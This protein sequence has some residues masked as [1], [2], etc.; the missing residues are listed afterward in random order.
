MEAVLMT[1]TTPRQ[2]VALAVRSILLASAICSLTLGTALAAE[3]SSE[4]MD[5]LETVTVTGSRIASR[6]M[7]ST[8]PILTVTSEDI[9]TGGRLD[10]TDMLNQLPQINSNA[11]G[12]DLGNRTSGLTSAGGVSTVNLRG[13]GANRTLLLVDGRRLGQGSPQTSISA[14]APDVDQVPS[15]LIERV[16]V[17][18]GGASAVYGSDAIAGVVN[19]VMK[20]NFE[21]VQ[22]DGQFGGNWHNNNN[23][24]ARQRVTDAG[25]DV[26][27]GNKWDGN[28]SN[29][30]L[31]AGKNFFDGRG[32][33]TAY[34][35]HSSMAP[36]RSSD[37]DFGS[38]M[39]NYTSGLEN[40]RC[41][42]SSNANFFYPTNTAANVADG[43][44]SVSGSSF[45]DRGSVDT[46]P[47]AVFNGQPYIYMQRDDDRY[48]GGL[49][50]H[51]DVNDHFKPYAEFAYMK[52]K[53][54]QEVAPTALFRGSNPLSD[55]GNYL[56][57]CSNPLLSAQQAALMC[58]P[59][60]IAA[61]AL[62]PGSVNADVEIGRRNVEGGGRTYDY[63]HQNYR[64]VLGT[65]GDL[66]EGWTYD[67]YGQYYKV[68]FNYIN[69]KD[70]GFDK[71]ANALQVSNGGSG[72]AC[73]SGGDC[74]PYNIF[75]EGAVTQDMLD[76]LTTRGTSKGS[77]TLETFHA[78]T[79]GDLG[80]YGLQLPSANE[81]VAIN[82]GYEYRKEHVKFVPD[83]AIE[84]GLIVGAGGADP[85][86]SNSVSVNELSAELRVPIASGL[87]GVHD[88]VAGA[89]YRYSDYSTAGGVNTY[90]F[91][92]Q[93]APMPDLRFRASF[94]RAIRAP[95]IVELFVPQ[96]VGKISFG[97]DPCAPSED[98]GTLNA[99]FE[100]CARTGVTQAQYNNLSIPQGTAGQLTQLQGGNPNLKPESADTLTIGLTLRPE[101]APGFTGSIDYYHIKT[102][103][104]V[105]SLPANLILENCLNTGDPTFCSQLVRHPVT[106]TLNGAS[107]QSGGYIVKTNVNVGAGVLNGVDMQAGYRLPLGSAGNL[108][109]SLNSAYMLSNTSTPIP[110]GGSYDCAGLFG[111]T[112]QTV[113]PEWRHNASAAWEMANDVTI[114][115]IWRFSSGVKLDHN[116]SDP[117]LYLSISDFADELVYRAKMP[118][119]SYFDLSGKW[120]INENFTVRAGINNL[121]D[122]DP[123]IAP[124]EI[125]SGGAPN[126]YEYYD[127]LGRQVFLA[128][129][130]KF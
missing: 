27:T 8:S 72:P 57:N 54:H 73:I 91:D 4:D 118:A 11:L 105:S 89:G 90:K 41:G 100:Q 111:P 25:Y 120:D 104:L 35:S 128:V 66:A 38:C 70:F 94:N 98:D 92:V 7:V 18:T 80:V 78:D 75:Q 36:V 123:P 58:T 33:A 45:V 74:V 85:R 112:C 23:G 43:V 21:G 12:Q 76:Y 64:A 39:M 129:T 20:K 102:K 126:Y 82:L 88:L 87:P 15:A 37:R 122:K 86:I 93:Y 114:T 46:T 110:G 19:F 71:I 119:V 113:N 60:E 106:G 59:A 48:H 77:T 61:D 101:W 117:D 115:G 32:N 83:A 55:T 79:T 67:A 127:A 51:L 2:T 68:D 109:V 1:A 3:S 22:F 5:E 49:M 69:G 125:I 81:G 95:S 96:K 26:P 130:A 56:I 9:K 40:L 121:F 84:S 47:P 24:F 99:T 52:D 62:N 108:K 53:T 30:S 50:A 31:T 6:N 65:K 44:Y 29:F 14:P 63:K 16:E 107:V 103:G 17:V 116:D 34:I 28:T 42:G 13:L 10:I 124:S 97:E